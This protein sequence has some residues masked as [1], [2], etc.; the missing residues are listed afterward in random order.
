MP[1]VLPALAGLLELLALI[2]ALAVCVL[3]VYFAKAF[4][5]TAS[6]LLG[7]LPIV[8]G[9]IDSGISAVE[10]RIVSVF[11][12]AIAE[13]QSAIGWSWH[14]MARIVDAIGREIGAHMGLISYIAQ[15]MPGLGQLAQLERLIQSLFHRTKGTE[16]ALRGIG[17]D[18]V[19]RVKQIERGIGNDVLPRIQ[20]LEHEWGRVITRDIPAIRAG[21][22]TAQREI[23]NL[24]KWTRRHTLEA[25]SL[26]FAGAVAWAL[27]RIGG[28]WIRCSN[29]N[30]I[31]RSVCRL[32]GNLIEE[33]FAGAIT[34]FAVGDLCLFAE[35]VEAAAEE[36]APALYALVDVE[37]AL[38]GCH[39]ATAAPDLPIPTNDFPAPVQPLALAA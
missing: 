19:P 36:F 29:W 34:A 13:I 7:K 37:N 14:L 33:L 25:G 22:R 15:L 21:E 28:N 35:G 26:A 9:W 38:I 6:G 18:V 1:V 2:V 31:G 30:R 5:G 12:E 39:G 17:E 27:T 10:H 4:L 23:T 20:S 24:W 16:Q 8:G 3:V 11:S 32:P